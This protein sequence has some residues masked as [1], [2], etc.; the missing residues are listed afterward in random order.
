MEDAR[1]TICSAAS[2]AKDNRY[3]R[4]RLSIGHVIGRCCKPGTRS[5]TVTGSHATGRVRCRADTESSVTSSRRQEALLSVKILP[6]DVETSSTA[7]P[8]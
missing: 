7:D 3:S 5:A 8:K 6:T 2:A 1:G 4:R